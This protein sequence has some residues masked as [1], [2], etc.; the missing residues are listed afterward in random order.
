[1]DPL[2]ALSAAGTIVQFAEFGIKLLSSSV[3]LY[4]SSQGTLQVNEELELITSDLK[5]VVVKLR[6]T[7]PLP[8]SVERPLTEDDHRQEDSFYRICDEAALI[9]DELLSKLE[10][11]RMK[12]ERSPWESLKAAFK[13]V[14]SKEEITALKNRLYSLRGCLDSQIILSLS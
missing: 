12:G 4:K 6:E 5:S 10:H 1:M 3:K 8:K 2:L 11:L 9:A 13:V 7:S 14:F